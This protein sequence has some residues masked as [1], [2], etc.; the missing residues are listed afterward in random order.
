[1]KLPLAKAKT[2][3]APKARATSV[4][5]EQEVTFGG[6]ILR[7]VCDDLVSKGNLGVI[8]EIYSDNY[9]AHAG[10]KNYKGHAFLKRYTEQL[11]T[12]IPDIH[13]LNVE[14]LAHDD[15]TVIWQRTLQGTHTAD[16]MGIPPSQKKV[17]WTE[18]VVTLIEGE[19]IVEEWVVSE[20]A[21]ELLLHLSTKKHGK[22]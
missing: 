2:D 8:A 19:K 17:A 16:L 6:D 12:A 22:N 14:F 13:V 9:T 1:M 11:R 18:M 3:G 20:L 7:F 21:G 15:H 10:D 5:S 4:L